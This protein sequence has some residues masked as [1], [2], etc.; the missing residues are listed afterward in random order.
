MET[1]LSTD[2]L[3][4]VIGIFVLPSAFIL[5]LILLAQSNVF[6][7]RAEVVIEK[8]KL[9]GEVEAFLLKHDLKSIGYIDPHIERVSTFGHLLHLSS[10]G[11]IWMSL[12]DHLLLCLK[13]S[14]VDR[15]D[16]K[17]SRQC[18]QKYSRAVLNIYALKE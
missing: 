11:F 18:I 15:L 1:L 6:M 17:Y 4:A 5:L 8:Q 7:S 13:L 14:S 9:K 12:W 3:K 2:V 16:I 10:G